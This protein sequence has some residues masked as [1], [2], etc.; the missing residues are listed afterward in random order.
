MAP[1]LTALPMNELKGGEAQFLI[2]YHDY[3]KTRRGFH[4]R[5]INS[6]A[7]W[8]VTNALSFMNMPLLTYIKEIS[9][10]PVLFIHGENAHSRYFSE[11]AYAAAR[12]EGIGD[13]PA[14]TTPISTIEWT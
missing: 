12:A 5:S 1:R 11:S 3:Y 6:N 13:H 10:R 7:S 2:D 14:R 4:P 8:T 9:P